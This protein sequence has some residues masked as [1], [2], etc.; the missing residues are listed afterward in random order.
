MRTARGVEEG[1]EDQMQGSGWYP[2]PCIFSVIPGT[3]NKEECCSSK[4]VT[5]MANPV[6]PKG[7]TTPKGK[8]PEAS[9]KKTVAALP[10]KESTLGQA[11][12]KIAKAVLA[13]GQSSEP[14]ARGATVGPPTIKETVGGATTDQQAA[15]ATKTTPHQTTSA[16]AV[17]E[18][19]PVPTPPASY[20]DKSGTEAPPVPGTTAQQSPGQLIESLNT[21][22]LSSGA[23]VK[24]TTPGKR[25]E[26]GKNWPL[27][28]R[29][30]AQRLLFQKS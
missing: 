7:M 5:K 17:G 4:S 10:A 25:V 14:A 27:G 3:V 13:Q 28:A 8:V 2:S 21:L 1:R 23:Q 20:A 30:M 15:A 19:E 18:T 24:P 9:T 16:E 12:A 6:P 26:R 11:K 29:E 22:E